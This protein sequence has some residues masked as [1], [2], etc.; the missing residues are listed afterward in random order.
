MILNAPL[1]LNFEVIIY[2]PASRVLEID[3]EEKGVE[4]R[5]QT[6]YVK[7]GW[8]KHEKAEVMIE[9]IM[10]YKDAKTKI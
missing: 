4:V 9:H 10:E 6:C 8:N 5:V 3:S 7:C 1:Y 2:K